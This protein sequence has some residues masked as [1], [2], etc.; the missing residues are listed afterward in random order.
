MGVV[1]GFDGALDVDRGNIGAGEGAVVDDLLD[2]PAG[3]RDFGREIS[4]AAGPI[5]NDGGEPGEPAIGDETGFHRD[6][7]RLWPH[8]L[9]RKRYARQQSAS[10]DGDNDGVEVGHLFEN[11]QTHRAL[12]GDDGRI[13]VTIDVSEALFLR[14]LMRFLFRFA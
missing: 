3:R 12:A 10:A 2:T 1:P 14:D 4:E 8:A 11:L 9:D 5:A 7:F 6:D 13:V